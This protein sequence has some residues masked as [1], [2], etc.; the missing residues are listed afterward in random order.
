MTKTVSNAT[1]SSVGPLAS[2]RMSLLRVGSRSTAVAMCASA[3]VAGAC[4]GQCTGTWT[5]IATQP[6][7]VEGTFSLAYNPQIGGV[8]SLRGCRNEMYFLPSTT[9]AW[10]NLGQAL[11]GGNDDTARGRGVLVWDESRSRLVCIGSRE[12]CDSSLDSCPGASG[13]WELNGANWHFRAPAFGTYIDYVGAFDASRG[14]VVMHGTT[15]PLPFPECFLGPT[16]TAAWDGTTWTILDD[17]GPAVRGHTMAYD[18]LR[19]RVLLF[20]GATSTT[21]AVESTTNNNLWAW[22]GTSWSLIAAGGP[23]PRCMSAMAYDPIRDRV[24]LHGGWSTEFVDINIY[25]DTWEFDG[26]TWTQVASGGPQTGW[27]DGHAM[28]YDPARQAVVMA[29]RVQYGSETNE[30]RGPAV[31]PRITQTPVAQ[32]VCASGEAMFSVGAVGVGSLAYQWQ[33]QPAGIGTTWVNLVAGDNAD[34]GGTPIVNAANVGAAALQARPL[35]GYIN[36]APRAFRCVVTNACGS[37]SSTEAVLTICAADFNCDSTVDFF[38]Y[39]DFV[40]SFSSNL[41]AAD[42]NGDSTIDFFDYLD[43]VD[44]FSIGC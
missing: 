39:L 29:S 15:Y 4:N 17:D 22:D 14:N 24:V 30:W 25:R 2:L 21:S 44:A 10:V 13:T 43:F 31:A 6:I 28:V 5:Q 27:N 23:S 11:V 34:V 41:A 40:D 37:V 26:I 19:H 42:F 16:I 18:N 32:S 7:E 20:G 1:Q 38:D 8:V 33:W 12:M 9:N 36:F 35:A 3:L